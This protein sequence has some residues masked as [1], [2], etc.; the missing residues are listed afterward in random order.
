MEVC[1]QQAS[2]HGVTGRQSW[3]RPPD[4]GWG[5]GGG[6]PVAY[7]TSLDFPGKENLGLRKKAGVS[8][9]R[10]EEQSHLSTC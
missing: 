3:L 4:T 7:V 10:G 9:P 8:C 6:C 2:P 1:A 5:G